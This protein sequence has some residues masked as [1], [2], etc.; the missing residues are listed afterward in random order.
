[1]PN[2][3]SELVAHLTG[4]ADGETLSFV[5]RYDGLS[6][7]HHPRYEGRLLATADRIE[8]TWRFASPAGFTGTFTMNRKP[9]AQA[10]RAKR[11][12]LSE[13]VSP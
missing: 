13:P 7:R 5:K 2:G 10:R 8:G 12:V 11:A 6:D 4:I 1:L 9:R 3:E